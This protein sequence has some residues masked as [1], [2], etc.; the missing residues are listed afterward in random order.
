M[1]WIFFVWIVDV[2]F[3]PK[4]LQMVSIEIEQNL[5]PTFIFIFLGGGGNPFGQ[6]VKDRF[7]DSPNIDLK[8]L[9]KGKIIYNL[10]YI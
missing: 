2:N 9:F 3:C 5:G 6:I 8:R 1:D 10:G 7:Y 4:Q